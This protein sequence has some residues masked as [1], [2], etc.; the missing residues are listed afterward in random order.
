MSKKKKKKDTILAYDNNV[1]WSCFTTLNFRKNREYFKYTR[2]GCP[3]ETVS[4]EN[5]QQK[6]IDTNY[7]LLM[8][9]LGYI[10]LYWYTQIQLI[11][12]SNECRRTDVVIIIIRLITRRWDDVYVA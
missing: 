7:L 8:Y 6:T 4:I 10:V 2:Y 3:G 5:R 12:L 9:P 11:Q 1:C